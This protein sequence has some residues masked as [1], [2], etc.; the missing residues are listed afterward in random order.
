P[1]LL[2][3]L[4]R[5]LDL[6]LPSSVMIGDTEADL[7][8]A[9]RAGMRA[10]LLRDDRRCELCPGKGLA[11]AGVARPEIIAPR[12]DLLARGLAVWFRPSEV[13]AVMS[14]PAPAPAPDSME[15]GPGGGAGAGADTTGRNFW[16]AELVLPLVPAHACDLLERL[17]PL[18]RLG[19]E[20][21]QLAQ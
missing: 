5:A 6:D 3:E 14:A 7:V 11:F 9:A 20:L 17:Q 19:A 1:G 18:V 16:R 21:P 4:A 15:H 12:L 13:S 8:A 2:H 10:A